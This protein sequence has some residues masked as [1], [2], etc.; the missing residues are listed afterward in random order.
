[1]ATT[2]ITVSGMTC[3]H[4]VRA[5]ESEIGSLQ[6]V[7][8]VDIDLESGTVTIAGDPLPDPEALRRAVDDA[9]YQLISGN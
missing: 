2:V 7:S 5:V 3:S 9:G 1:M 4:C 6:G 8:A